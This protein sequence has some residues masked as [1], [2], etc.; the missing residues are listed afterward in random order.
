MMAATAEPTTQS[1]A[2]AMRRGRRLA[3]AVLMVLGVVAMVLAL[4][5]GYVRRAVVDSDQFANR[6][7]VALSD[8]SVR[9]LVAEQVTDK[10]VLR[11]ASDL[12]AARPLIQSVVSSVVDGRG[13]TGAFRAGVRDV[14]RAVFARD[15]NTA[16][17][18]LAD[19]GTMVAAGLEVAQPSLARRIDTTRRVEVARRDLGSVS[20]SVARTADKVKLLAPLLL[21]VAIACT[22]GAIWLSADRRRTVVR[23]GIGAAA[24]GFVVIVILDVS[25]SLLVGSASGSDARDAVRAVWD[26]FLG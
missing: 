26:A 6:A 13:F 16:T 9:T 19:V 18:A 8:E 22:A 21:L 3:V 12:T 11:R 10:L 4:M 20:A 17:L 15:Q 24:G 5:A 23:L 25:R 7:T 14:H 1:S 2:T